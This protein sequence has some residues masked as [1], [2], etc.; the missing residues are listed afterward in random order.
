MS[1]SSSSSTVTIDFGTDN[2]SRQFASPDSLYNW[3]SKEQQCWSWLAEPN[4]S[5]PPA[6]R[7]VSGHYSTLFEQLR[8]AIQN[9]RDNTETFATTANNVQARYTGHSFPLSDSSRGEFILAKAQAN[10]PLAASILQYLLQLSPKEWDHTTISG[11]IAA[12]RYLRGELTNIESERKALRSLKD[13]WEQRFS[14]NNSKFHDLLKAVSQSHEDTIALQSSDHK[15]YEKLITEATNKLQELT[16][17]YDKELAL[18]KPVSYWSQLSKRYKF[19]AF[20]TGATGIILGAILTAL[21]VKYS[22]TFFLDTNDIGYRHFLV[23]L[24]Y[25]TAAFGLLRVIAKLFVSHLH[26]KMDAEQRRT[27]LITFLALQRD[28]TDVSATD[29]Q[30]ILQALFRPGTSGLIKEDPTPSTTVE[31]LS[32]LLSKR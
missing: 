25:A 6:L 16:E 21:L 27:M 12:D 24:V 13:T 11:A 14:S 3:F 31:F 32:N 8:S 29:R 9:M 4:L 10:P 28:G 2:G 19:A 5:R 22:H 1:E 18:R 15:H 23:F 7:V 20:W 17:T 26:V 30:L